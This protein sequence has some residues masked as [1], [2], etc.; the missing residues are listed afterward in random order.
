MTELIVRGDIGAELTAFI[1]RDDELAELSGLVPDS[2]VLTLWGA[3]GIGKTR[4]AVRLLGELAAGQRGGAWLVELADL[5]E[6]DCVAARI[7][8]VTGVTQEPGRPLLSTLA[9]A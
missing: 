8:E 5:R 9:D 3:G 7:A 1:G 4:L 6:G 2:P